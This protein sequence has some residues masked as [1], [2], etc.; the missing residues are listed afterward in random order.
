MSRH[1]EWFKKTTQCITTSNGKSV[2]IVELNH[3]LDEEI[4]NEW[5]LH[6][7]N[8]YCNDN[9]I[10]EECAATGLSKSEFLST[11]KLPNEPMIISGD[12]SEILVA[13]YI[14]FLLNYDVP[15][16]RYEN[17]I[18]RNTSP[19]GID[20]LGFKIISEERISK[21]DILLTCEVKGA[22]QNPKKDTLQRALKDS[23]KDY[24]LRKAESLNAMKRRLKNKEMF[25]E[26]KIVERFQNI[27]DRPYK[28]V[29]GMAAVHSNHT[30]HNE[31]I[32]SISSED[33]PNSEI[34]FI[35]IKGEKLME[36][37]RELYRRACDE[38]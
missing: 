24:K 29:S 21:N 9:E 6:L 12:F 10:D 4:L 3:E 23:K 1:T 25:R 37:A 8:H 11:I 30:W 36:L 13:D 22:L 27:T 33:H 17:K 7:R 2:D 18:N 28:E 19:N 35:T 32:T 20:V 5:A 38:T 34:L 15:R 31:V 16:T 14:Q 26:A